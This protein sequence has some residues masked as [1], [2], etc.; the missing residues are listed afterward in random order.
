MMA[1]SVWT[2]IPIVVLFLALQRQFVQ[3]IVI[4]GL[5]G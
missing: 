4:S 1:A 5:K 3:G 2:T